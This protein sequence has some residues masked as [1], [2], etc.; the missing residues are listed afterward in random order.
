[1]KLYGA[2]SKKRRFYADLWGNECPCSQVEVDYKHTLHL[3]E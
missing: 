2:C 1:M 3:E